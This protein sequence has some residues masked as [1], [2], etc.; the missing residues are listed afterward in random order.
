MKK[1]FILDT[2]VLLDDSSSIEKL[3]DNGE[4]DVIIP[5]SCILEL[6][7]LKTNPGKSYLVS[8]AIDGITNSNALVYKRSDFKYTQDSCS[9]SSIIN[10]TSSYINITHPDVPIFITNDKILRLRINVELGIETEEY[11][12][13]K[14]FLSDTELYT[15]VMTE[16]EMPVRNSF[17]WREGHLYWE[18]GHKLI[19]Y[20]NEIW[21][22]TPRT[23]YQNMLMEL[24][25]DEEI[26]VVS[27][28]S[29]PGYG[30]TFLTLAAA[31]QL[32]FQK[33][34]K[35]EPPVDPN[36][37]PKPKKRGRKKKSEKLA[38]EKSQHKY[39][40][41]YIIRPTTILGDE[42]GFL[43][44]DLEEKI[45]P[46]FRPIRDLL[47][48]LHEIRPCNRIF[49]DGDPKKGIDKDYLEFL[50][51]TYLRGMNI[52][53]AVVIID[54]SQNLSRIEM[55]TVLSRMGNNVRVFLTGDTSQI[56]SKYL[57]AS[58]NGLNWV[59]RMFK[60][61]KNYAHIT[62][63]GPKSRGEIADLVIKTGL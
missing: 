59:L 46:Y 26:S 51:I 1:T 3:Y 32:V 61:Q 17:F 15:G 50:P 16:G 60:D 6:D 57:N 13:S 53:D 33:E 30:K 8:A 9:D 14:P 63:K 40:K 19:D 38:E 41:V 49:I 12:N 36:E 25:L 10:D 34:K 20:E 21:K 48:K 23:V 7:R 37:P 22:I 42:L 45:D 62:L 43:P 58:N 47:F 24:L 44:G 39:R 4:N 5:Y 31:L 54:E 18:K 28:Q 27:V 35:Q 29:A 56:D 11:K 52:E 55:R 2:N